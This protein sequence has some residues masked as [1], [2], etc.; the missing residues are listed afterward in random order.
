MEPVPPRFL[1]A[2]V[3]LFIPPACR[4][5]IA[6][7]L[8]ERYRSPLQYAWE[9]L[10]TVPLVI[11]S[12]IRRTT[13]SQMLLMQAFAVYG[14]F[15]GA[16]WFKDAAFLR[17]QWG[18]LRL[19]IPAGVALVVMTLEDAYAK[20]GMR[21]SPA[22]M[23]GPILGL[24]LAL[25]SQ[26]WLPREPELAV[27][28]WILFYGCAMSLL[29]SSAIRMLFPPPTSQLVHAP[30]YWLTRAG[31]P[32]GN[33]LE[34]IRILKFAAGIVAVAIVASWIGGLPPYLKPRIGTSALMMVL[35]VAWMVYKPRA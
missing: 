15:L 29:L 35:L 7:D 25:V 9:A 5:E 14:S 12:R 3:A 17:G 28:G 19:A 16:A 30:A 34:L 21:S 2:L 22:L 32:G 33:S 8:C 27:P 20:P 18:L 11:A 1:E 4:E 26:S 6:G 13:D 10:L 23:R 31:A 24:G